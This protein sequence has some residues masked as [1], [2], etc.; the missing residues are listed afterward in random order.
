MA[1]FRLYIDLDNA[2]FHP[3]A[4]EYD[5]AMDFLVA[6]EEV[7]RI[8]EELARDLREN[9]LPDGKPLR[10]ANGNTVGRAFRQE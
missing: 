2:A 5:D 6:G 7:G 9:G 4:D 10:D 1:Q 8:L 3:D